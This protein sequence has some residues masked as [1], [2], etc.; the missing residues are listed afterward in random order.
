[1]YLVSPGEISL[2]RVSYSL[3]NLIGDIG[4]VHGTIV[5]FFGMVFFS[6]SYDLYIQSDL[7]KIGIKHNTNLG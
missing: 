1:M 5:G 6:I 7:W 3:I 4:G 2:L